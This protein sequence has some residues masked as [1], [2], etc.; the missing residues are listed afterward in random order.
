MLGVTVNFCAVIVGGIL[1]TLLRGGIPERYRV[2]IQQG[3]ALCVLAI[4]ISGAIETRN[5]LLVII[6]IVVGAAVGTLIKIETGVENLGAWAQNKFQK[7]GFAEGFVNAT[8]LFSI[9]SMA[10][11]G[12]LNA[13]F[14]DSSTLLAKAALDGVTSVIIASTLGIGVAFS[15]AP[16]TVYQGGIALLAGLVRP[17]MTDDM[18]REM[19]AVG[20][21]LIVAL[22]LNMLGVVKIKVAN[23]LP[24]MFVPCI[25]FPIAS[26]LN[27]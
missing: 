20:S 14:G 2:L 16:M 13:G 21:L 1:G 12:S 15:A 25:Y 4:G 11:V 7:G 26:L 19:G 27:L 8:L 23:M 18:I 17:Y 3:I 6:S 9:G 22:G 5:M 24:A 10:V